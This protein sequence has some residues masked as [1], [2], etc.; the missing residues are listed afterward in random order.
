M[1]LYLG[2]ATGEIFSGEAIGCTEETFGEVVLYCSKKFHYEILTDPVHFGRIV[3]ADSHTVDDRQ[4]MFWEIE[5]YSP[6]LDGLVILGALRKS[7][8]L[9]KSEN[10]KDYLSLNAITGFKPDQPEKLKIV[11]QKCGL[12]FGAISISPDRVKKM[13]LRKNFSSRVFNK[14]RNG[15]NKEKD[16][17]KALSTPL[18]FYWDFNGNHIEKKYIVVA[19]D[20]GLPYSVLRNLSRFGCDLR[21]VPANAPPEEVIALKPEGILLAGGPGNPDDMGYAVDNIARLLGLRPILATGLGH[22]LL[23]LSIGAKLEHLKNPHFGSDIAVEIEK[24]RHALL[25]KNRYRTNQA[26]G[27]GVNRLSVEQAGFKVTLVNPEDD[28]VEGYDNEDYL[29]QSYA[30]SLGR[31]DYFTSSCIKQFVDCMESHRARRN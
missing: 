24:R 15:I 22:N 5:S 1:K 31:H 7:P 9:D 4:P 14:N 2:L 21:V 12:V 17:V 11:L 20:F 28:S 18:E 26:H 27:I 23:A 6:H 30:F 10:L 25:G 3:V 13:L 29:I 8:L 16:P 19:Y